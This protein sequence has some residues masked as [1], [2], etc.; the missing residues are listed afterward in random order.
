[1][2]RFSEAVIHAV[3]SIP[4]GQVRSYGQVALMAGRPGAARH[5]GWVLRSLP[6]GS[7]VPWH[8][9][10]N[11]QGR[12]SP[13]AQPGEAERQRHLLESEGVEFD[14]HGKIKLRIL[15]RED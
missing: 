15:I 3:R 13:R 12:I 4:A 9:V 5:V 6:E 2:I 11:A 7:E 10:V 14:E 8:R 1:M